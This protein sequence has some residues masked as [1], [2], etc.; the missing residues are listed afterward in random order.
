RLRALQLSVPGFGSARNSGDC[1]TLDLGD[2]IRRQLHFARAHYALDLFGV[3]RAD[4]G[5][6]NRGVPEHPGNGDFAGA[7]AM[8]RAHLPKAFHAL[9]VFRKARLAK[10]RI[11][12]AKIVT[13]K[14][15]RAVTR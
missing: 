10:F 11:A 4:D 7:A 2:L 5:A 14:R 13:R 15:C 3:S 8:A 12:A 6:G 9:E 1:G